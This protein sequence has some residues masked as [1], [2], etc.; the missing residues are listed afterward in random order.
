M[1]DGTNCVGATGRGIFVSEKQN[2]TNRVHTNSNS[3]IVQDSIKSTYNT[4]LLWL[5]ITINR[6]YNVNVP[7]KKSQKNANQNI[8]DSVHYEA[9]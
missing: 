6:T 2:S 4:I 9:E 1:V 5:H 3:H 8:E 7:K